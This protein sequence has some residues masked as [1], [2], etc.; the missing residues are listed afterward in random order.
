MRS[1]TQ[2]FALAAPLFAPLVSAMPYGRRQVAAADALVLR[3]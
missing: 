1:A 2:L 3:A